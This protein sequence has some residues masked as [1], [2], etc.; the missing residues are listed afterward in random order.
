MLKHLA[1]LV[2]LMVAASYCCDRQL[3]KEIQK[4]VDNYVKDPNAQF[5]FNDAKQF[6]QFDASIKASDIEV[7]VPV[8]KYVLLL[9]S[10]E[11][12]QGKVSI[13]KVILETKEWDMPI[14]VKN[15]YLY[16][17]T[18]NASE[19]EARL[20]GMT[21]GFID[22]WQDMRSVWPESSCV[23]PLYISATPQVFL[24]FPSLGSKNNLF[25]FN[26]F[27]KHDSL[28]LIT[29]RDYKS[30]DNNIKILQYVKKRYAKLRAE[31]LLKENDKSFFG[32]T[33]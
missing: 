32:K 13:D 9:D 5:G 12:C 19:P 23:D 11:K 15:K 10:L 30:P 6:I 21:A 33:K 2:F 27:A 18:I 7:G 1:M 8:H 3:P 26:P 22:K 24:Y 14:R 28:S 16:F 20:A 17:V 31:Y 29:S 25:Y 4:I